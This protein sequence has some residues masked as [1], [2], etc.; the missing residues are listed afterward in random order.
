ML[1]QYHWLCSLCCAFPP[2]NFFMP[3]LE[4]GC[5]FRKGGLEVFFDVGVV[6]GE[7]DSYVCICLW[8]DTCIHVA[9]IWLTFTSL[10]CCLFIRLNSIHFLWMCCYFDSY[11]R[12]EW[13]IKA[14][15]LAYRVYGKTRNYRNCDSALREEIQGAFYGWEV[16]EGFPEE[17]TFKQ[18]SRCEPAYC[19]QRHW[20]WGRF[21]STGSLYNFVL[22]MTFNFATYPI[23]QGLRRNS[24]WLYFLASLWPMYKCTG[25]L[26]S[27]RGV[28]GKTLH[29]GKNNH[30]IKTQWLY[31]YPRFGYL[32]LW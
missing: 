27:S 29:K 15:Q 22:L 6:I 31:L 7:S 9:K 25:K 2:C 3:E 30:T 24:T 1:F 12:D 17:V 19:G 28:K 18:R 8:K 13:T 23:S 32:Y 11:G 16:R 14:W 10:H 26:F 5:Y 4:G 21:I 20:E